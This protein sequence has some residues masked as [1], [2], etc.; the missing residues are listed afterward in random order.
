M[1]VYK[2]KLNQHAD[3]NKLNKL[4]RKFEALKILYELSTNYFYS[5]KEICDQL[6]VNLSQLIK[7][8]CVTIQITEQ[9]RLNTISQISRDDYKDYETSIEIPIKG[10]KGE[11]AGIITCLDYVKR[12]FTKDEIEIIEIFARHVSKEIER[13]IV[14]TNRR[15]SDNVES[16]SQVLAALAHQIRN[17]LNAILVITEALFQ[18]IGKRPEYESYFEHIKT[19]INRLSKLMGNLIDISSSIQHS[20]FVKISV[21]DLFPLVISLWNQKEFSNK[22]KVQLVLHPDV[23][24]MHLIAN[25]SRLQQVFL[26]ILK[27]AAQNSPDGTEIQFIVTKSSNGNLKIKIIDVGRGIPEENLGK[28]FDLFY[29]TTKGEGL[30]L[31]FCKHV[32]HAHRGTVMIYNNNP[33]PGCTVEIELPLLQETF[34]ETKDIGY[35]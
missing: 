28:V 14:E 25:I 5:F 29:T 17:P 26:N 1:G 23:Q 27:N 6:V 21:S 34:N 13:S 8:P 19:Q 20:Q 3:T 31:S 16:L 32:I 9:N 18:E 15:E 33:P 4:D 7:V 12:N 24:N 22:H 30:G 2:K 10:E 11:I 35:R